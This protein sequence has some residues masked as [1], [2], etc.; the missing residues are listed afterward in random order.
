LDLNAKRNIKMKKNMELDIN[1]GVTNT[2][3]RRN[4]FYIDRI[5]GERVDQLPILP[6]IG[7][8]F[9]F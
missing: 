5:T 7:V 3:D 1:V 2:Y 6:N 4:V 8:D 9:K